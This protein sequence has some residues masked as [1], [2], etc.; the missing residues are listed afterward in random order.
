MTLSWPPTHTAVFCSPTT[1]VGDALFKEVGGKD[2]DFLKYQKVIRV[3]AVMRVIIS[4]MLLISLCSSATPFFPF[5]HLLPCAIS[6][7]AHSKSTIM[8]LQVYKGVTDAVV[9]FLYRH[10]C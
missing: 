10:D 2:I 5:S 7:L 9:F 3:G 4:N 6:S 1:Q 8:M